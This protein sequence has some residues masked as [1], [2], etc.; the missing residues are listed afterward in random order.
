VIS[1]DTVHDLPD[2]GGFLRA[3]H[4]SLAPGGHYLMMEPKAGS[5]TRCRVQTFI[6]AGGGRLGPDEF[7]HLA[8]DSGRLVFLGEVL[9]QPAAS[10]GGMAVQ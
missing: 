5:G 7:G 1:F 10:A 2:P 3:L 6:G 4:R 9:V 8:G